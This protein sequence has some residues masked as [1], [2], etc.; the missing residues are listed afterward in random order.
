MPQMYRSLQG[1]L[2]YPIPPLFLD[3]PTSAARCLHIRNDARDPSSERWN[4]VGEKVPVILPK[5]WLPRHLGI[6]YMPQIYD[7]GPT[8][9]LP[10]QRKACWERPDIV[11]VYKTIKEAYLIDVTIPISFGLYSN[12]IEKLQKDTYLK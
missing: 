9:L 6:F 5:W 12:I 3:I 7:M 1:L 10:L 11:M 2:Y 8:A 4:C